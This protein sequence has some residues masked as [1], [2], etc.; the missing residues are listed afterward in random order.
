MSD[1]VLIP[2]PSP[3]TR[4]HAHL[5]AH[6]ELGPGAVVGVN[7]QYPDAPFF[8]GLKKLGNWVKVGFGKSWDEAFGDIREVLHQRSNGTFVF[9][10][11]EE[12]K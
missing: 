2:V 12:K 7:H 5:L 3:M 11:E 1:E 10:D 8:V 4:E 9:K 6:Q